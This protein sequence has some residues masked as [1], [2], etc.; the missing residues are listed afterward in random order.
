MVKWFLLFYQNLNEVLELRVAE[1][2]QEGRVA[3][4]KL[5]RYDQLHDLQS[6]LMLVAGK[7]EKGKDDVDRFMEVKKLYNELGI[8]F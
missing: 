5:Y 7:A 3:H 4:R 8:Q 1:D 2:D 6:R